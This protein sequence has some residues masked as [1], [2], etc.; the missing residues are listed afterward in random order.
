MIPLITEDGY[1]SN[2]YCGDN[3]LCTPPVA[4]FTFSPS[5][6]FAD[7]VVT[8]DASS[9]RAT[10]ANAQ[11]KSYFWVW[12][13]ALIPTGP[14][15]SSVA[16]HTF[17]IVG[18]Y[19]VTLTIT[20]S[21]DISWSI[22][23]TVPV[24]V[25]FP[26][27]VSQFFTEGDGSALPIDSS[28]NPTVSVIMHRNGRVQNTNPKQILSCVNITNQGS[29]AIQSLSLDEALP[30]DWL[31]TLS[32]DS[33]S[34]KSALPIVG[35]Q[36]SFV[37]A[38]GTRLDIT[39]ATQ[40]NVSTGFFGSIVSISISNMTDTQARSTLG[41]GSSIIVKIPLRYAL[42][43]TVQPLTNYPRFYFASPTAIVWTQPG[44]QG[45]H[46]MSF[47]VYGDFLA[48]AKILG[49]FNGDF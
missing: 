37:F 1:F 48:K 27:R 29:I 21:Y 7:T 49:D 31:V 17:M 11:A 13:D 3:I 46:S 12:G 39:K 45:G 19:S 38:N 2:R 24:R 36:V 47:N 32:S 6:P 28:G 30:R 43:G 9:S 14:L 5:V 42:I 41:R 40:V 44:F 10:N 18:N 8:F 35:M 22:E 20:D 26:P 16:T 33:T 23:R 4:D 34:A 15:S 25:I